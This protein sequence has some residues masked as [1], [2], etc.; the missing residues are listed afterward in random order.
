MT[1][2]EIR[3]TI[4]CLIL[5]CKDLNDMHNNYDVSTSEENQFRYELQEAIEQFNDSQTSWTCTLAKSSK[6]WCLKI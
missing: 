1:N 4:K 5:M 6:G 3:N 2:K